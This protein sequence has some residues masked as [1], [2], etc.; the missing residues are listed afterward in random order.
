MNPAL[1]KNG[2]FAFEQVLDGPLAMAAFAAGLG[3]ALLSPLP[4]VAP[5]IYRTDPSLATPYS[6]QSSAAIEHLLTRDTSATV[7]YLFVRGVKL[8]R[9]RNTNLVPSDPVFGTLHADPR[10][11]DIYQLEDS[12]QSRYQGLSFS[13]SH[14]ASNDFQFSG[15]YTLSKTWD[16][17]SD[18]DEQPQNPFDLRPE[19]A[20]SRQDQRHRF[21]FNALWELPIGENEDHAG[22]TQESWIARVLSHL[23]LAPI[24]TIESGRPVDPLTGVDSY[25]SHAFPLSARPTGLG[26]NSLRTPPA[27][28]LNLRILKYFPFGKNAKLDL[29]A[30]A[31]NALNHSNVTEINP[32]FGPGPLAEPGFLQPLA[33]AGPRRIQFS[34]DFE[35]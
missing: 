12:A 8:S 32:V 23:E 29:V 24:L 14:R 22:P 33:G 26:R 20:P 31:F 25:R 10:F 9:T 3:G 30:E 19:W 7:S 35:F 34:L 2:S 28:N 13:V 1:Q 17:A 4:G 18:F 27:A 5:S 16:N 11:N 21:V 15:G 6:Q